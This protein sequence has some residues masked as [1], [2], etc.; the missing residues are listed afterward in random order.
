MGNKGTVS[1]P[2]QVSSYQ[3]QVMSSMFPTRVC[4]V[5]GKKMVRVS[6]VDYVYTRD[7]STFCSWTC[8]RKY[9]SDPGKYTRARITKKKNTPLS[10]GKKKRRKI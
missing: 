9:D 10:N 5:C 1:L 3:K 2:D 8:L 6:W 7:G 4:P